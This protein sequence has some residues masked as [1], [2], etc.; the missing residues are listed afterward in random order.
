MRYHFHIPFA[1]RFTH[2]SETHRVCNAGR[3]E[4][5]Y[6]QSGGRSATTSDSDRV[7]IVRS[8]GKGLD[9]WFDHIGACW[10]I[11]CTVHNAVTFVGRS[12]CRGI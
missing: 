8:D 4:T 7:A 10:K 5:Y 9:G 11:E 6:S 2:L 1:L 3:T 12:F